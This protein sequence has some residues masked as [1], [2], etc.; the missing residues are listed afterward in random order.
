MPEDRAVELIQR[1]DSLKSNRANWESLWDKV[2][3]YVIP[4]RGAVQKGETEGQR[5]TDQIYDSTACEGLKIAAAG[6][7]AFLCPP[8]EPWFSMSHSDRRIRNKSPV[9]KWLA[10]VTREIEEILQD[11]NF[12]QQIHEAFLD[13]ESTGTTTVFSEEDP[14]RDGRIVFNCY[15]VHDTIVDVNYDGFVD[16]MFRRV[17]FTPRQAAQKFGEDNLPEKVA[18]ALRDPKQVGAKFEF[19]HYVG[20]NEAFDPDI[21]RSTSK[22]YK[23]LWLFYSD[24]E[25]VRDSESGYD[26]LPYHVARMEK[27]STEI[28]GRSSSIRMLPTIALVNRKSKD[29]LRATEKAIDPP[30]LLPN[31][32]SISSW[33]NNPGGINYWNGADPNAKPEYWQFQGNL[34][35]GWHSIER[36]QN[37]IMEGFNAH[38]FNALAM[39]PQ[40][41]MTATEVHER[42]DEKL[43]LLAPMIGRL[44]RELF[45][46]IIMRAFNILKNSGKLPAAPPAV[47]A[48][49]NEDDF[50]IKYLGKLAQAL[51][52]MKMKGFL[53]S[54]NQISGL[55]EAKPEILDNIN[56]D[57]AMVELLRANSSPEELIQSEADRD[58]LREARRQQEEARAQ[59]EAM[60][61]ASQAISRT[62]KR[63]EEG[64][65]AQ[66]V[67]EGMR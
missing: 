65:P 55:F 62:S 59:Q 53:Q 46:P 34:E 35:A 42:V 6:L 38:L 31:D 49:I 29:M 48:Q 51:R 30:V 25:I 17:L 58:A 24:K 8:S 64:S 13:L 47:E 28:Y 23:S 32:G 56:M 50:E 44:Q 37:A 57:E 10:E 39:A 5:Q 36:D 3:H 4:R 22:N 2:V 67:T 45:Q 15:S 7:F 52:Q 21:K 41:D 1:Y 54:L 11:S 12:Y 20:K 43:T 16:T 66:Q 63:P 9:K 26:Q 27:G 61:T 14:E 60:D 40:Q 33:N 19:I 18:K